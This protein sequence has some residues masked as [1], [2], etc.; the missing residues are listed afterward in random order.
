MNV[1]R[2]ANTVNES[3][4]TQMDQLV[5]ATQEEQQRQFLSMLS[6]FMQKGNAIENAQR[7]LPSLQGVDMGFMHALNKKLK[8]YREWHAREL[9]V[10]PK[11]DSV[12]ERPRIGRPPKLVAPKEDE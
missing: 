2:Y 3:V 6:L 12:L 9:G 1:Q 8:E 4:R 7:A 5:N 11:A 10:V